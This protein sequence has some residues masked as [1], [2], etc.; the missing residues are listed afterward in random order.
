MKEIK[1]FTFEYNINGKLINAIGYGTSQFEADRNAIIKTM[2][3]MKVKYDDIKFIKV[4]SE[5]D[6]GEWI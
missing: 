2:R 4:I 5:Q 6:T 3:N 1:K